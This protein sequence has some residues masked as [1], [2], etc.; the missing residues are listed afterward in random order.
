[1]NFEPMAVTGQKTSEVLFFNGRVSRRGTQ[2]EEYRPETKPDESMTV[3]MN[4]SLKPAQIA[5]P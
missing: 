1:M 2:D 3:R 4:S 5:F